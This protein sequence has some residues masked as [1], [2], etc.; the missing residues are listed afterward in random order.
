MNAQ[1]VHTLLKDFPYGVQFQFENKL[2]IWQQIQVESNLK[3][4]L[5]L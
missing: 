2:K 5:I 3:M 4:P 1:Q